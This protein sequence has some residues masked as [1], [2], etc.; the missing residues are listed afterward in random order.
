[1][2]DDILLPTDGST[3]TGTVV[4]H[5]ATLARSHDATIHAVYVVN[6]GGL[7][8]LAVETSDRGVGE[9]LKREGRTAVKEVDRLAGD[10]PVET[11]LLEGSPPQEI[12]NYASEEACDMIVMGT[13]GRSGVNRLLLGSVA[14]R[15]VR[16]SPVPVLT[17][18]VGN[19]GE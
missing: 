15:V 13:H 4:E 18:R 16:G 12:L 7:T 10:I 2:Y 3:K 5:A 8:D 19:D 9:T 6:T 14:E 11:K 17:V 1:M